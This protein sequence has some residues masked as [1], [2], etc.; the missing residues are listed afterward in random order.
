[1]ADEKP[2]GSSEEGMEDDEAM[3]EEES[4]SEGAPR[5]VYLPGQP[6]ADGEEL[7]RDEAAYRL[8]QRAQSGAPCLSFDIIRDNLGSE[9]TDYPLTLYLCAGTQANTAQE[10]RLLVMKMHN[11]WGTKETRSDSESES[12]ES[13]EEEE[14]EEQTKPQL[15]IAMVPHYGGVNRVRVKDLGGTQVA[16]VWSEKAQVEVWELRE[17]LK[18]LSQA[19]AMSTFLREKQSKLQPIFAFG[20]HMTEGFAVDWS[21]T[22][23]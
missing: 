3:E 20:G 8:Y 9:R 1:M 16:A 10:N 4:D 18:A 17:Q 11:L 15:E 19:E 5:R 14:E 2:S 12:S 6:L 21:P 7:V 13:D 23:A 22:V